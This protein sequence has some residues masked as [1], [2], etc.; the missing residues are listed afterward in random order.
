MD[1]INGYEIVGDQEAFVAHEKGESKPIK[2]RAGRPRKVYALK[3]CGVRMPQALH[4][5]VQQFCQD[6]HHTFSLVIREEMIEALDED[7]KQQ[8]AEFIKSTFKK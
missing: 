8:A 6:T 5:R 7:R 2:R 3:R 4:R 1:K